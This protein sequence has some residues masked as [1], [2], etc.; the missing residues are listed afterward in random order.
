MQD[1]G[2]K[3]DVEIMADF[4]QKLNDKAHSYECKDTPKK[5]EM[6]FFIFLI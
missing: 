5:G 2:F 3:D 1:K 4:F 6:V